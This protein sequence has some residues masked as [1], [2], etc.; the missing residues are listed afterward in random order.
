M[1]DQIDSP[2]V[3]TGAPVSAPGEAAPVQPEPTP[4]EPQGHAGES[5]STEEGVTPGET[6]QPA[7]TETPAFF[8]RTDFETALKE[9]PDGMKQQLEGLYGNLN[10]AF[11]QGMQGLSEDR[12]KVEAYN[13]FDTM[14]RQ[15]PMGAIKAIAQQM[16]VSP[17]QLQEV[18][19]ETPARDI[20]QGFETYGEM[21][22]HFKSGIM[23][24]VRSEL[25]PVFKNV[26]DL[27]SNNIEAELGNIDPHWRRYESTM[28]DT[29]KQHPTLIN[30]IPR[31]YKMSVPEDVL[32]ADATREALRRVEAETKTATLTS[33]GGTKKSSTQPMKVD[34]FQDAIDAARQDLQNRG[35]L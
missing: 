31:L 9:A 22:D 16:G 7:S 5:A 3:P 12:K 30:D 6:P 24:A 25:A 26:Q 27:T 14:S 17:Q 21:F 11:T 15:D 8:N 20:E 35:T 34:S 13:A 1:S 19:G 18:I 10:K 23:D 2:D 33:G 28:M 29:M 4:V 32:K